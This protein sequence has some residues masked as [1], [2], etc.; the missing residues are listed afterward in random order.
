MTLTIEERMYS[1]EKVVNTAN[2]RITDLEKTIDTLRMALNSRTISS[3]TET[4]V[5]SPSNEKLTNN[6]SNQTYKNDQHHDIES[7]DDEENYYDRSY[8]KIM[9]DG[10]SRG[11]PGLCGSGYIIYK[12]SDNWIEDHNIEPITGNMVVSHNETNNFAEY[13]ALILAL[14]K[15]KELGFTD[16]LILGDSK[17]VIHQQKGEWKCGEKL[18]PLYN[19]ALKLLSCFPCKT[20]EHIPRSKNTIADKLANEAMDKHAIL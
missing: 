1:L 9:F 6:V 2:K 17:L 13:F 8:A 11:N 15:A 14:R 4:F 7:E 3:Q 12:C 19:E 20:L 10:G 16:L 18:K 5:K